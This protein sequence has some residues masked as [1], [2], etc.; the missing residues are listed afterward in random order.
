[1]GTRTPWGT[2]QESKSYA[3][4][5]VLYST[6]GHGGFHLSPKMNAQV[7][8]AIRQADGW[9]EE[10][11]E[12]SKVVYAFPHL[13]SLELQVEALASLK[14]WFPFEYEAMTGAIIPLHES[15]KKRERAFE[16]ATKDKLVV[17]SA[18]GDWSK[19]CPKGYVLVLASKG[20]NREVIRT[21][22]EK[23]YLIPEAEYDAREEFGFIVDPSRHQ[24]SAA[25]GF[26]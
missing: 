23:Y 10:D 4:G 25:K 1:M 18:A 13:F 3:R 7:P 12:Y 6:A 20:G 9:Y 2:A 21:S 15:F 19:N 26:Y 11:C 16:E 22:A 24:E 8:E 14:N 17:I 5:V